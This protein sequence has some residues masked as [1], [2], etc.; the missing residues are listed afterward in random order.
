MLTFWKGSVPGPVLC[1][2][3]LFAYLSGCFGPQTPPGDTIT[4][5]APPNDTVTWQAEPTN[6]ACCPAP[7]CASGGLANVPSSP[8][9]PNGLVTVG[10]FTHQE[11]DTA[12]TITSTLNS[13]TPC[14]GISNTVACA[15][16]FTLSCTAQPSNAA[17]GQVTV[18]GSEEVICFSHQ[19]IS[20]GACPSGFPGTTICDTGTV[21]VTINGQMVSTQLTCSST[22]VSVAFQLAQAIDQ[23]ATLGSQFISAPNG[24]LTYVHALNS[25]TQ[26][27]YPWTSS[28]SCS[29][30]AAQYYGQCSFSAGLSPAASLSGGQ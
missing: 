8:I 17:T 11:D 27:N 21:S 23:N 6:T 20:E 2:A 4:I 12:Y 29:N 28:A 22:A 19:G 24:P 16:N 10:T 5:E 1:T 30:R 26:Y 7:Q 18:S 3:M 25:G 13:P 14:L 9:G 15:T